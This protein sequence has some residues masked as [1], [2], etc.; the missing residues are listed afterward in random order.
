MERLTEYD[1]YGNADIIALS[2]IMP[3]LYAGLSFS[4]TNAL[5]NALN[6]LA[7]YENTGLDPH[8]TAN[9]R[10]D[11]KQSN[12]RYDRLARQYT[13]FATT[14]VYE[15]CP[16]CDREQAVQW[17]VEQDGHGLYCPNCGKYIMLC[18]ECP[19]RDGDMGCDWH[20]KDIPV[21]RWDNRKERKNGR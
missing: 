5:T 9:L 8:E 2:D 7:A 11:L 3:E 6:K 12:A 20:E 13:K 15:H 17:N 21:C 1:E 18:S 10:L 19:A 16:H 4:Q 14:L